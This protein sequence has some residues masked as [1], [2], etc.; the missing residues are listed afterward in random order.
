M[1]PQVLRELVDIIA[2]PLSNIF[3]RSWRTGKVPE[4]SRISNVTSVIKKDKKEDP[5]N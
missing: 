5:G 4:D 3:K 2:E 1:H